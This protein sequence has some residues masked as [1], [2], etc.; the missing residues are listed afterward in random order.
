MIDMLLAI[1]LYLLIG[2]GT[3]Y[4]VIVLHLVKAEKEGYAALE[5]W[6]RRKENTSPDFYTAN[7]GKLSFILG[8]FIWPIKVTKFIIDIPDYHDRYDRK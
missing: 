3:L 1:V 4:A 7:S 5:W 6:Y 8:L 2:F